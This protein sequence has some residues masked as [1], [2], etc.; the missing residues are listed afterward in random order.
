MFLVSHATELYPHM[1]SKF[2]IDFDFLQSIHT[3]VV[4]DSHHP[5]D[6]SCVCSR[7][8]MVAPVNRHLSMMYGAGVGAG[9][10]HLDSDTR[11]HIL[12]LIILI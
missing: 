4:H 2:G 6:Q 1:I 3:T 10:I 8:V 9:R 5:F 7:G 12:E 11:A